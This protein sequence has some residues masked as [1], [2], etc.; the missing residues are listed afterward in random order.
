MIK[1]RWPLITLTALAIGVAVGRWS[2]PRALE[3]DHIVTSERDTELRFSAYV[4]RTTTTATTSTK[5]RIATRWLPS[6]QVEQIAEAARDTTETKNETTAAT[7]ETKREELHESETRREL[8]PARADWYVAARAGLDLSA[9]PIF[10][11]SVA[12]RVL[13]PLYFEAW[14]MRPLAAGIGLA[15]AF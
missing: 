5:W 4:G 11:G 14:A 7:Q 15:L 12:R 13:G 1:A 2:A 3:R 10:G 6:G 9:R 8:A